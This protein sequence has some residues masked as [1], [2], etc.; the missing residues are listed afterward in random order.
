L[1]L[2]ILYLL[3]CIYI[4]HRQIQIL[5]SKVFLF[6]LVFAVKTTTYITTQVQDLSKAVELFFVDL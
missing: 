3:F 2:V 4:L 5:R 6:V 1:L